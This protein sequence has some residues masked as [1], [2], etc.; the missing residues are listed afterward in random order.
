[1]GS[2]VADCNCVTNF[3]VRFAPVTYRRET[4]QEMI[5]R[6]A[7]HRRLLSIFASLSVLV[8]AIGVGYGVVVSRATRALARQPQVVAS[9]VPAVTERKT[10]KPSDAVS[11]SPA[12][13]PE[14]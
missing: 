4:M 5:T 10:P 7:P 11:V 2:S 9:A 3:L 8:I 12:P 14:A 1:M 13:T 6:L